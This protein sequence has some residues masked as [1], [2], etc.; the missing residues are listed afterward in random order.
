MYHDDVVIDYNGELYCFG[1]ETPLP[2]FASDIV[3]AFVDAEVRLRQR[4]KYPCCTSEDFRLLK[5]PA[6]RSPATPQVTMQSLD[7]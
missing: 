5:T 4:L 3:V 1:N 2:T 6:A 7:P